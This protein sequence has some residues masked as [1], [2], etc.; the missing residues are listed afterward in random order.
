MAAI[1]TMFTVLVWQGCG[2]EGR[3]IIL[4]NTS[5]DVHQDNTHRRLVKKQYNEEVRVMKAGSSET[6]NIIGTLRRKI[7][8]QCN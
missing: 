8:L 4:H 5:T 2:G 3:G 6:G 1:V 7:E